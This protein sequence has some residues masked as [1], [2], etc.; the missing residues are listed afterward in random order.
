MK[1]ILNPI[2]IILVLCLAF[3][4]SEAQ[5]TRKI[6]KT[7]KFDFGSGGTVAVTGA[8]QGSVNIVGS[9][10]NEVEI[11]ATITLNAAT[12]AD[13][14]VLAGSTGFA[15]EETPLRTG[16][17]SVGSHNK[18]GQKKLPKNFPKILLNLPFRIDYEISVPRFSDIEID[19]GAGDLSIKDVEGSMRINFLESNADINVVVGNVIAT[20]GKGKADVSFG[21]RGWRGRSADIQV[22]AGD[23]TVRLPSTLSAE[24]DAAILRSGKIANS[25]P[26]LKPRDR[27]VPFTDKLI[28]AKAGVGGV[29]LKFAVGDGTLSIL[30]LK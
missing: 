9:Q 12:E 14:D 24:L 26:D 15:T 25:F 30:P 7:D 4:P 6:T 21:V 11:T 13:L 18:F 17:L 1:N 19:G 5:V 23:L 27:K 8:P 10:K 29:P 2:F 22:G 20:I 16:I 3:M 28:A